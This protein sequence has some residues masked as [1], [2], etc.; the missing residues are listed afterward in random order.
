MSHLLDRDLDL[1]CLRIDPKTVYKEV[2]RSLLTNAPPPPDP[3]PKRDRQV[4]SRGL[5]E[6]SHVRVGI[7]A[8]RL[9]AFTVDDNGYILAR[10]HPV[11]GVW[12]G[13]QELSHVFASIVCCTTRIRYWFGPVKTQPLHFLI[14]LT[15]L[16][17]LANISV[18]SCIDSKLPPVNPSLFVDMVFRKFLFPLPP[19]VDDILVANLK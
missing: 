15:P 13:V 16:L 3:G 18:S 10:L 12:D 6:T 19:F 4:V 7:T 9:Y 14:F 5:N 1:L 17:H 8:S 11:V 2:R